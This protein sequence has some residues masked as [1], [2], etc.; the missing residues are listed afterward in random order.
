MCLLSSNA[1]RVF[2]P[3]TSTPTPLFGPESKPHSTAVYQQAQL[4]LTLNPA[5]LEVLALPV[6]SAVQK[7]QQITV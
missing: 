6:A 5:G 1:D 2:S 4:I 3:H 7:R